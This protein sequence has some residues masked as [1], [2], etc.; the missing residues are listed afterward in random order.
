MLLLLI[1]L[2]SVKNM[3]IK[4]KNHNRERGH[5]KLPWNFK[6]IVACAFR[7]LITSLE[8]REAFKNEGTHCE[9]AITWIFNPNSPHRS[10]VISNVLWGKIKYIITIYIVFKRLHLLFG[11]LM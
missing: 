6:Y 8:N 9:L 1:A 3:Q 7:L 2:I 11:I 4:I 5:L 10:L